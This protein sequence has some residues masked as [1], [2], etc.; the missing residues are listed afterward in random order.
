MTDI[1][2]DLEELPGLETVCD[3]CGG[4]NPV[5]FAPSQTWNLVMGGPDAKGDPGG[6]LCPTCFIRKAEAGGIVPTAW[7]VAPEDVSAKWLPIETAPRDKPVLAW[8][9]HLERPVIAWIS[10]GGASFGKWTFASFKFEHLTPVV[11]PTLWQPLPEP[12]IARYCEGQGFFDAYPRRSNR[13]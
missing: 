9:P 10:R 7:T 12:P 13:P 1:R 11:L 2:P 5:W 6:F 3:E 4:P 8:W